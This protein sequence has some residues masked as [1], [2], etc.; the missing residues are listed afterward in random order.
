[1]VDKLIFIDLFDDLYLD[2]PVSLSPRTMVFGPS[3]GWMKSRFCRLRLLRLGLALI[4]Q[5]P[6]VAL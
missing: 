4:S 5:I 1:L 2:D 3:E 6:D